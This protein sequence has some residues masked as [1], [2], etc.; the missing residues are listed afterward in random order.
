MRLYGY[1]MPARLWSEQ[2]LRT[3]AL[4]RLTARRRFTQMP[5]RRALLDSTKEIIDKYAA[6]ALIKVDAG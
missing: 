4:W 3:P 2:E 6:E 5:K 1:R